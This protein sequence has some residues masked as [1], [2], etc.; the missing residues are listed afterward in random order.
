[1]VRMMLPVRRRA[2]VETGDVNRRRRQ[3]N[4]VRVIADYRKPGRTP[5]RV[6]VTDLSETGCRCDT[7]SRTVVGDLVWIGIEG[8]SPIEATIRWSDHRGFGA[9]WLHP[10]HVSVFDHI[11]R[12]HPGLRRR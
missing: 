6:T 5:F 8:F 1:M 2:P 11:C 10:I 3:R 7:T 12:T 4:A 9:E